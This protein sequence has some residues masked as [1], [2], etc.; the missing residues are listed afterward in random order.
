MKRVTYGLKIFIIQ[1]FLVKSSGNQAIRS[2]LFIFWCYFTEAL[3]ISHIERMQG[4]LFI[5]GY[6]GKEMSAS[7]ISLISAVNKWKL[8]ICMDHLNKKVTKTP[9]NPS[10][11][12][13]REILW[14]YAFP[15][16]GKP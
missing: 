16:G 10:R 15:N 4:L 6:I 7:P 2:N 9:V 14:C 5:P 12:A 8:F 1:K 11:K 13:I 3:S